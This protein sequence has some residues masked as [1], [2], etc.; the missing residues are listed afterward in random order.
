MQ[1]QESFVSIAL[2]NTFTLLLATLVAVIP[3]GFAV[4]EWGQCAVSFGY[5]CFS[6]G[7]I[8]EQGTNYSGS[9]TCDSG[10]TCVYLNDCKKSLSP[11]MNVN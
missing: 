2:M 5:N 10:L 4:A 1:L 8:T 9:K 11:S 3:G 6:S 7:L